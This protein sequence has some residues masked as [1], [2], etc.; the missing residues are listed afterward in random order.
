MMPFVGYAADCSDPNLPKGTVCLDNPLGKGVVDARQIIGIVIK[1]VLGI[2]GSISLLMMVWGG[3]QWLT[4]AG[5]QEKVKA[6]TQT[7]VWAVI[8][9]LLVFSSFILVNALTDYLSGKK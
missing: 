5:N 3:F 2:I 7:M 8:G 1:G 4:S 9:V 6:G